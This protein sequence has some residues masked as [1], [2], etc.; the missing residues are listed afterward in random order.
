MTLVTLSRLT[1]CC[2]VLMSFAREISQAA[3]PRVNRSLARQ[4]GKSTE[5]AEALVWL[6]VPPQS[7]SLL[8]AVVTPS[9]KGFEVVDR[10]PKEQFQIKEAWKAEGQVGDAVTPAAESPLVQSFLKGLNRPEKSYLSAFEASDVTLQVV[11]PK[12]PETITNFL[13]HSKPA[14]EA[15]RTGKKL[16]FVKSAYAG[17]VQIRLSFKDRLPGTV[18][19]ALPG[20]K[21]EPAAPEARAAAL[22][23]ERPIEFAY[24]MDAVNLAFP[25][26]AAVPRVELTPS[27]PL[28]T[29]SKWE[30][31]PRPMAAMAAPSHEPDVKFYR[32][33]V[34]YASDRYFGDPAPE[35]A[36][37]SFWLCF[38]SFFLSGSG[39]ALLCLA[40]WGVVCWYAGK[41]RIGIG[42]VIL[43]LGVVVVGGIGGAIYAF[44]NYQQTI[45]IRGPL[46]YGTCEVSIPRNHQIGNIEQP[47]SHFLIRFEPEDPEK[48][49]VV[50]ARTELANQTRIAP[51]FTKYKPHVTLYASKNDEALKASWEF[52]DYPRA[53][54]PTR[55]IVI[56]DGMDSIDASL[57]D[58]NLDTHSYFAAQKTVV[59]DLGAMIVKGKRPPERGL[60]E[61]TLEQ[62]KYWVIRPES[63]P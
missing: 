56:V 17:E 59:S 13:V 61:A 50:L 36:R 32:V 20:F 55:G 15:A 19:S 35:H 44:Q 37:R 16:Y 3:P 5:G 48:H 46:T 29:H 22:K 18:A 43:L 8:G 14:I 31:E 38:G 11:V 2:L 7:E 33:P 21:L 58:T 52:H 45:A 34:F 49:F 51:K 4:L 62:Q 25:D 42:L 24:Q 41:V 54:D 26:N 53:G 27:P 39:W 9:D 6:S 12:T 47:V 63:G 30:L 1:I 60:E 23:S 10:L 57:L 28:L 40:G